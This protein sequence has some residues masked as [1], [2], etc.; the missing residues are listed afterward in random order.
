MRLDPD[1]I[2]FLRGGISVL[3]GSRDACLRPHVARGVGL[4]VND[5]GA[6]LA[7]LL[8]RA[9]AAEVLADL[10]MGAPFTAVF[11]QPSTHR[12]LQVKTSTTRIDAADAADHADANAYTERFCD[13]LERLGFSRPFTRALLSHGGDL[14]AVRFGAEAVFDQTPG[15]HAGAPLR[16]DGGHTALAQAA[17]ALPPPWSAPHAA[18]VAAPTG[19][20]LATI[21]RCLEGAVPGVM[22]TCA[23][24]GTPNVAYLSQVEYVDAGHVAL[25]YQFFNKTRR[26][27][28]ANPW[29]ELLVADG[30]TAAMYRLHLRYLRT[31]T[32][33]PLFE[34]MKAKLAGIASLTGMAEVFR[35]RGSDVFQVLSVDPVP[36][37]PLAEPR[38][39]RHRLSALRRGSDRLQAC[40]DLE[41]L[42]ET[43]LDLLQD[44]FDIAHAMVL[45]TDWPRQ[46]LYTI[47]SRGYT[48]SGIGSEVPLGQGVIGVA[49]QQRTPIR[50]G[51]FTSDYSYGLAVREQVRREGAWALQTEIPFPGLAQPHSQLAVPILAQDRVLG[52]LFV[53]SPQDLRFTYDDEDALVAL[54]NQAGWMIRL[55]QMQTEH[56]EAQ[57]ASPGAAAAPAANQMAAV[58]VRYYRADGSVFLDDAYLIKGV[59]GAVLWK[60]LRD[61]DAQGRIEF[62]NRELRLDPSIPLPD[63]ADN[64]DARLLLLTRRLVEREAPIRIERTGRGRFRLCVARSLRLQEIAPA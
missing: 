58:A 12:T 63:V 1:W 14:V 6:S 53:E 36:M 21:R 2:A 17:S 5:E 3:V 26:N 39:G 18:A 34:R 30:V 28:L 51:H 8:D 48:P 52:V 43:G 55:F 37:Q 62:T 29:C 41:S 7:V 33:G 31:E 35:L 23:L 20:S 49:A 40:H 22:A 46:R 50:I 47:A 19:V 11:S 32:E 38:A 15:P 64:L 10:R 45:V 60:L 9:Q 61:H 56:E 57:S 16:G 44:A 42:V 4:Y 59:A 54:A 25:S 27:L 13:E 24:D